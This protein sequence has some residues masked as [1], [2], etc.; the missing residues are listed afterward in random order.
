MQERP[1]DSISLTVSSA[2]GWDYLNAIHLI[3]KMNHSRDPGTSLVNDPFRGE[4]L[5]WLEHDRQGRSGRVPI[6]P[7]RLPAEQGV[8]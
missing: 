2:M 8:K 5:P 6:F 3:D 7:V 4:F 1:H